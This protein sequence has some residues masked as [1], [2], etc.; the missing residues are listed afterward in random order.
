MNIVQLHHETP[1]AQF[2]KLY[3]SNILKISHQIFNHQ[4]Y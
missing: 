4:S 1:R 3:Q 2:L